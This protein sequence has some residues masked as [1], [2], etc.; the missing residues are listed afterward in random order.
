[1]IVAY[2]L[3]YPVYTLQSYRGFTYSNWCGRKP[4]QE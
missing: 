4:G 2:F 1:M 3:G